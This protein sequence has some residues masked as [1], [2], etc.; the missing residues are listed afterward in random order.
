MPKVLWSD[1]SPGLTADIF[2]DMAERDSGYA[3]A[4]AI[5]QLAEAQNR[6]AAALD[7]LGTNNASPKSGPGT[8]EFIGMELKRLADAMEG[9][10]SA[11]GDREE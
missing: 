9:V 5:I 8:T 2:R 4:W 7:R 11:L 1:L 10:A 6:T 3:V